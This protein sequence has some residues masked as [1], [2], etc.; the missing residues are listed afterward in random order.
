[1]DRASTEYL[2][3]PVTAAVDP[4]GYPVQIALIAST[5]R[6]AEPDWHPATW[7]T[8]DGIPHAQLLVGPDGGALTLTA[9]RWRPWLDI[10]AGTEHPIIAA[11][12]FDIT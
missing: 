7:T 8:I 2:Q 1:M 12:A 10:D 3:I 9:G 6:P 11:P 5:A 4:T